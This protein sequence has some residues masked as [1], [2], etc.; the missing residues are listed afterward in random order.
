MNFR[1]FELSAI[2]VILLLLVVS[3][4][5]KGDVLYIGLWYYLAVP[6]TLTGLC[7]LFRPAPLFLLGVNIAITLSLISYLSINWFSPRPEGMLGLGHLLSLPGALT[8]ALAAAAVARYRHMTGLLAL[9][10]SGIAGT[11]GGFLVAQLVVCNTI[12]YCGRASWFL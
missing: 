3:I 6:L 9:L 11:G 4:M 8:G 5:V 1:I 7:A 2:A 10:F 12:F